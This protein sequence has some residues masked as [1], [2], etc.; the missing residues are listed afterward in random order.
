MNMAETRTVKVRYHVIQSL[1]F[2]EVVHFTF[3]VLT[4]EYSETIL[5]DKNFL[6]RPIGVM[7]QIIQITGQAV[8]TDLLSS[9]REIMI[10]RLPVFLTVHKVRG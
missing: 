8:S 5:S 3:H 4:G 9:I 7:R 6:V 2:Q 10:Q 1:P